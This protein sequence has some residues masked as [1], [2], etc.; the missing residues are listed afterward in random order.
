MET[1][2]HNQLHNPQPLYS[3]H[4]KLYATH[5][6]GKQTRKTVLRVILILLVA[7]LA[8]VVL[9]GITYG[10]YG[11]LAYRSLVS[12]QKNIESAKA[13]AKN[14]EL[15][16]AATYLKAA[17]DEIYRSRGS[18][19]KLHFVTNVPLL[20]SQ[21]DAAMHLVNASYV[22]DGT[23][24]TTL[25]AANQIMLSIKVPDGQKVS[26]S[27]LS[28]DQKGQ[29]LTKL[30]EVSPLLVGANQDLGLAQIEID[31]IPSSGILRQIIGPTNELKKL[32][33]VL[34]EGMELATSLSQIG[35]DLAGYKQEKRYLV[36]FLNN[37]ELR[38]GG[39]FIGSYGIMKLKNGEIVDFPTQDTLLLDK[40]YKGDT[41]PDPVKKYMNPIWWMRDSN[42]SPDFPTSAE[43]VL[44][45]YK[46]ES[47]D[48]KNI[49]GVI[50]ITPSVIENLIKL[51]G[52]IQVPGY[53]YTFT[54]DRFADQLDL[55]VEYDYVDAGLSH[56]NRKQI[57][58]DLNKTIMEKILALPQDH[59][60]S[61]LQILNES[62]TNKQIMLYA[63][64]SLVEHEAIS[65]ILEKE[66]WDGH[67]RSTDSDFLMVVDANMLAMKTDP[68]V[69]R[70]YSYHVQ[71]TPENK[72]KARLVLTYKNTGF[73]GK[74]TSAYTTY[75]RILAPKG[76]KLVNVTNADTKPDVLEEH[77]KASFGF[78]KRIN[79]QDTQIVTLDYELP[80]GIAAQVRDGSY[81]LLVQKQL[82]SF[83]QTLNVTFQSGNRIMGTEPLEIPFVL[84]SN[85]EGTFSTKLN[86]DYNFLVKTK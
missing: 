80:E 24:A 3:Q 44:G 19:N 11:Y 33:P 4:A 34:Q 51:T 84:N 67:I 32:L 78:Y 6:G 81:K 73:E 85:N 82:G 60:K 63:T 64:K 48:D 29:I 43:T 39:G 40:T 31:K 65:A 76:T 72:L 55:A 70:T 26:F 77:G 42:W 45:F 12:A 36:L 7:V 2:D 49:D 28:S 71:L 20:G 52:P 41:P 10:T 25:D 27:T 47:G 68:V 22:V 69:E 58:G 9:T 1:I 50:G 54:A 61:I 8:F 86:R 75:T 59:W 18:L 16:K 62:I 23:L 5:T 35:P 15:P 21:Y 17:H 13:A 79:P 57:L 14:K 37:S 38:P 53:P 56:E 66:N 46:K 74:L 83:D 30:H